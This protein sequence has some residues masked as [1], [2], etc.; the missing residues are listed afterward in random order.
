M[1]LLMVG[2]QGAG[3]GT[4]AELLSESLSLIHVSTGDIFRT[5][6]GHDTELGIAAKAFMLPG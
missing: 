5:N 3:K 2:P 4:Q 1:R 6:V